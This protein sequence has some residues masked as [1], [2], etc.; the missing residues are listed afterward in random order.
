MERPE[1]LRNQITSEAAEWF[2]RLQDLDAT[3]TERDEFTKWLLLSPTHIEEYL[4]VTRIWGDAATATDESTEELV[5]RARQENEPQNVVALDSLS[6]VHGAGGMG[7]GV[8]TSTSTRHRLRVSTAIAASIALATVGWFTAN[9]WLNRSQIETA[10]GEQRSVTLRDGSVLFL[11]TDSHARVDLGESERRVALDRG[12][13]RFT[14]AKDPHRPFLVSTRQATVR[15]IGTVFNVQA[16]ATRTAVTVIEGRVAVV[17]RDA[18]SRDERAASISPTP[19]PNVRHLELA[20]GQQAEVTHDGA[21]VPDAG[22]SVERVL[23]WPERRLIFRDEP[24]IAVVEDFNRY[25]EHPIRIED[26]ALAGMRI[27]GSFYAGDPDSLVTYLERY[28]QVKIRT[29]SD[30]TQVLT[31]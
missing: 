20:A 16:S 9:Q 25:H 13:A 22:P 27:S 15:A 31:R 24:L 14:V 1:R 12:E 2:A 11:N 28:E 30:G 3:A 4:A 18:A 6:P 23:A 21:I 5:R 7:E 26:A 17:A 19:T 29:Q 10:I 8:L